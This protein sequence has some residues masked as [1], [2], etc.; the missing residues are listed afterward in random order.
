L[1]AAAKAILVCGFEKVDGNRLMLIGPEGDFTEA[2]LNRQS[3][4]TFCR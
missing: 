4:K 2:K 3:S 1:P